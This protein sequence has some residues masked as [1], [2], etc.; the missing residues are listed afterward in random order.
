MGHL[1]GFV[2]PRA[3]KTMLCDLRLH[4]ALASEKSKQSEGLAKN[5]TN[6]KL[7]LHCK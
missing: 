7:Q 4:R 5:P 6:I 2:F 3:A 1:I